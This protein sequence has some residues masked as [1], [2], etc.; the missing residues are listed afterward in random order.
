[1]TNKDQETK[2]KFYAFVN[3]W[4]SYGEIIDKINH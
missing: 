2:E 4:K 1:M 3:D